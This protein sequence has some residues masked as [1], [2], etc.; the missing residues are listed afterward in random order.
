MRVPSTEVTNSVAIGVSF[1][2]DKRVHCG[3]VRAARR[4]CSRERVYH[5]LGYVARERRKG[6]AQRMS[7]GRGER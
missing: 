3:P 1:L 5:E 7:G 6:F 2:L 4:L